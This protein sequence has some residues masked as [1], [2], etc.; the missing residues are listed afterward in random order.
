MNRDL[1]KIKG[2]WVGLYKR[3]KTLMEANLK[4]S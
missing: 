2:F 4:S 1:V 3:I